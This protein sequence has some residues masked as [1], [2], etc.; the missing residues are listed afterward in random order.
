VQH[1]GPTEAIRSAIGRP[2]WAGA[3][4]DGRDCA[5]PLA[6]RL[7][8]RMGRPVP[9]WRNHDIDEAGRE[10]GASHGWPTAVNRAVGT[11]AAAPAWPWPCSSPRPAF[12]QLLHGGRSFLEDKRGAPTRVSPTW[13]T[14]SVGGLAAAVAAALSASP[15]IPRWPTTC[16]LTQA[17]IALR[18]SQ[19][20]L[21]GEGL[22]VFYNLD[23]DR[24]I[25]L[26]PLVQGRAAN[27]GR[28]RHPERDDWAA[29]RSVPLRRPLDRN[30]HRRRLDSST[31]TRAG[32]THSR[33]Q[34]RRHRRIRPPLHGLPAS[35]SGSHPANG[36]GSSQRISCAVFLVVSVG[37]R[38]E[39]FVVNQLVYYQTPCPHPPPMIKSLDARVQTFVCRVLHLNELDAKYNKTKDTDGEW[40]R[41]CFLMLYLRIAGWA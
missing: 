9:A 32:S 24:V 13:P 39:A 18:N 12:P 25:A 7:R 22:N 26:P 31:P 8:P 15:P 29:I 41:L 33:R 30:L 34:R 17:A 5:L 11:R 6:H 36:V 35:A 28:R 19:P 14:S 2:R 16:A 23:A 1:D 37:R 38:R 4:G 20:A 21:R 3:I 40:R 27:V 10:A